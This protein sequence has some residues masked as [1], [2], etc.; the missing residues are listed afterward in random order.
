MV[1]RNS[2]MINTYQP[3]LVGKRSTANFY[4]VNNAILAT[5]KS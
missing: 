3:P 4:D 1:K 2:V 5:F